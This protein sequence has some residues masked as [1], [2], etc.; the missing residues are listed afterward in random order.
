[1]RLSNIYVAF[2]TLIHQDALQRH[3]SKI[4]C[5]CRSHEFEP[6]G[7]AQSQETITARLSCH[8]SSWE[9]SKL[10]TTNLCCLPTSLVQHM[11]RITLR[12]LKQEVFGCSSCQRRPEEWRLQCRQRLW[13]EVSEEFDEQLFVRSQGSTQSPEGYLARQCQPRPTACPQ[14]TASAD[15]IFLGAACQKIPLLNDSYGLEFRDAGDLA[16]RV[17]WKASY[18][19]RWND[20]W[21]MSLRDQPSQLESFYIVCHP[22]RARS[23]VWL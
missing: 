1:M 4:F 15:Q 18:L 12:S 7:L 16:R 2:Q 21:W 3:R 9:T 11:C 22:P 14:M 13:S 8:I 5:V 10:Y 17:E 23:N 19:R 20:K 6:E